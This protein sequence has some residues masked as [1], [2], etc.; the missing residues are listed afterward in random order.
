M[1]IGPLPKFH[2]TRDILLNSA[3]VPIDLKSLAILRLNQTLTANTASQM[4]LEIL[5][6]LLAAG[7]GPVLPLTVVAA[8]LSKQGFDGPLS[9]IRDALLRA[10]ALVTRGNP[11]RDDERAG[12]A[13]A[14]L[15][16]ALTSDVRFDTARISKSHRIIAESLDQLAGL[17][18]AHPEV[19]AYAASQGPRHH[20]LSSDTRGALMAIKSQEGPRPVNNLSTWVS[21]APMFE[22]VLGPDHPDTLTTRSNIANWRGQAG[23]P[24]GALREFEALL[25][26]QLRVLGADHP[27]TLWT[28]NNIAFMRGEAGDPAGALEEF[29]ALLVDQLRVLGADHPNTLTTRNNIANWRGEAGDPAG[30]LEEFEAL[31]VDRLRVL[32]ADHPNTLTTRN[33]IANWRGEAGDPAG[34]LEGFE[35]LL[36]DQLRVLGPDHPH[37]LGTRNNI[38]FMRGQAGD[39]AG[40]LEEFEALL[41]DELRV[42]GAN[43]PHTLTTRNNIANWRGQAGDPIGALEGFEAL[44]VDQLR[45]LG[46]DHR[47]TLATRKSISFWARGGTLGA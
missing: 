32:G 10:G 12:I 47:H 15:I 24:V 9:K 39:P 4:T 37:T 3:G 41:V 34:A 14:A 42:L 43:H 5:A 26:D 36:V 46:A 38:A 21:W 40:A 22:Q 27:D 19:V 31:L 6:L 11:G 16:P 2:G 44:L 8:A 33:N 23:D 20:L 13:H 35:A 29:E 30:A 45:V 18:E 28:R 7:T 25:V 1:I 17:P